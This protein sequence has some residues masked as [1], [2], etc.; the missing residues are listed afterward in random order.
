MN[1]RIRK[2]LSVTVACVLLICPNMIFGY[3]ASESE[4]IEYNETVDLS[5]INIVISNGDIETTVSQQQNFIKRIKAKKDKEDLDDYLSRCSEFKKQLFNMIL[6]G[7]TPTVMNFKTTPMN[8][9]DGVPMPIKKSSDSGLNVFASAYSNE[10]GE[11]SIH[12]DGNFTSVVAITV[13]DIYNDSG[14]RGYLIMSLSEWE[15]NAIWGNKKYPASGDDFLLVSVPNGMSISST[16]FEITYNREITE[17]SFKGREGK[18]YTKTD[19]DGGY[20]KYN[21]ADDPFGLTQMQ[22]CLLIMECYGHIA[23]FSRTINSYYIHTWKNLSL[24]IG[25]EASSDKSVSLSVT[26]NVDD[27]SWQCYAYVTFQG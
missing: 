24:E 25:I 8:L 6:K 5:G 1:R 21:F 4:Y 13:S 23:D 9:I 17:G 3:S 16:T 26:P 7:N 11:T 27:K 18:E 14:E 2:I 15:Q 19:G 22:S 10:V 12:G 20:I